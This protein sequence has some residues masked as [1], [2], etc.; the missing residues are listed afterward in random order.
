MAN[1]FPRWSNL[2]PLKIAVCVVFVV[3]GL[4]AAFAYYGTP[5]AQ[6]VGYQ[7][8]QPIDYDHDLHA[9]Q[10]GI[11]CRYCHSSVDK[12]ASAGV[13]TANTCWNCHQHV[14]KGNPKL[15]PLRAA[16]GVDENHTP[17]EGAE[18]KPIKWVRIHKTPDYAYFD[19]S[20]HVNRGVSCK[21]C[22]GDIHKMRKVH[23][24][25]PL[26]MDFCLNCHRKPEL[27][28]RPLEE[29]YNLDYDAEE[30]LEENKII[31]PETD[32]RITTQEEFGKLLKKNW[33]IQPKESCAT[34]HR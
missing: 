7:P 17:I 16:M 30:Y 24:V 18:K 23:H 27:H 12:S 22:H 8:D 11:D 1:F 33:N 28:L 20:A 5:K 6:R 32:K 34:C 2:L 31:D 21:S 4:V 13:P 15:A 14:Q 29:V 10:L 19:H 3:M 26:S 9:N 25:E